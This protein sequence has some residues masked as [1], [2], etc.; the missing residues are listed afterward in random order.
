MKDEGGTMGKFLI[1]HWLTIVMML[2]CLVL[3][4]WTWLAFQDL[5]AASHAPGLIGKVIVYQAVL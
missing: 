4:V 1:R 5:L 2:V 3:I